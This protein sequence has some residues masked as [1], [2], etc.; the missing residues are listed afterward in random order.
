LFINYFDIDLKFISCF[1]LANRIR[2]GCGPK[3]KERWRR[4]GEI[5]DG[6]ENT[7]D[8]HYKKRL[9]IHQDSGCYRITSR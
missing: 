7:T 1:Y 9:Y 3:V 2:T 4:G 6:I 5:T 8:R